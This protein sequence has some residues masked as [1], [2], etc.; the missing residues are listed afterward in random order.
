MDAEKTVHKMNHIAE[1]AAKGSVHL[2]LHQ[3]L[4]FG[5]WTGA[6]VPIYHTKLDLAS[7]FSQHPSVSAYY[8][9]WLAYLSIYPEPSRPG[10]GLWKVSSLYTPDIWRSPP[11][12]LS[13]PLCMSLAQHIHVHSFSSPSPLSSCLHGDFP[14]LLV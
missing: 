9:T 2:S 1:M 4:A 12:P 10:T 7:R 14:D 6:E 11:P 3:L 13:L 8:R 5:A